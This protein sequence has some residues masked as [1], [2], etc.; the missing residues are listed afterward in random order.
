MTPGLYCCY[1]RENLHRWIPYEFP[2][3]L[4]IGSTKPFLI[5]NG[6]INWAAEDSRPFK[7][8]GVE[9]RVG[10]D[11]CFKTTFGINLNLISQ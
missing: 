5:F 6:Y 8:G 1:S 9:M 10:Y 4:V 11:Y 3:I 2:N 7:M